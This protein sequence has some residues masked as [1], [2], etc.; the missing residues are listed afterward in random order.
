MAKN[1]FHL[2]AISCVQ[3]AKIPFNI[4][5]LLFAQKSVRSKTL[6]N[7]ITKKK[8]NRMNARNQC[9]IGILIWIFI[10]KWNDIL[11]G[12][13]IFCLFRKQRT[14]F[15]VFCFF[16]SV[17]FVVLYEVR[18]FENI[19]ANCMSF[20]GRLWTGTAVKNSSWLV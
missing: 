20:F 1:T 10:K 4:F 13:F 9:T 6:H 14:M 12:F 7:R 11:L 5:P 15:F 8:T 18:R 3:S 2:R 19:Y 16:F 17:L